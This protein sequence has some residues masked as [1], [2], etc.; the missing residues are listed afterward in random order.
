MRLAL[1]LALVVTQFTAA[2]AQEIIDR[3]KQIKC[4]AR[5]TVFSYFRDRHGETA[6]WSGFTVHDTQLTLIINKETRSWTMI[7]HTPEI[8]CVLSAGEEHTSSRVDF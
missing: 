2:Q 3:T 4:S 7:E 8:A 6:M 5:D 1:A